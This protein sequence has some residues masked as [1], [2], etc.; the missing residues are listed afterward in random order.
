MT[1]RRRFVLDAAHISFHTGRM[2]D[3]IDD[4]RGVFKGA[5]P[6]SL[7]AHVLIAALLI[8]GLPV[9][10]LQP[11]EEPAIK[12]ELVPPDPQEKAKAE[13]P[14]PPQEKQKPEETKVEKPPLP[15]KAPPPAAL[16][17]VD[18]F[19]EKDAG[20][21]KAEGD[22]ATERSASPE[23]EDEPA[24]PE[25]KQPPAEAAAAA[26]PPTS[27]QG[28]PV[29]PAPQ[30]A[31]AAKAQKAAKTGEAKKLSSREATGDA[32]ATTAMGDVPRGVR[33]GRLCVTELRD[34]LRNSLPPYFPDL[35]PSYRLEEGTVIDVPRAAFRV[36]G[37]WY[38]L[39][40][41][42]QVDTDATKVVSFDFRVGNMLPPSEW[43]RRGLPSQ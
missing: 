12:V 6:A 1:A 9:S 19:G 27:A 17:P 42:C 40:Y 22:S 24:K 4:Q 43:K 36:G 37:A 5:L 31:A 32:I 35:L 8:F 23:A 13:P 28:A 7:A 3:G 25:P 16:A 41:R 38:D 29:A 21:R 33:A 39:S 20:P 30:P 10:L 11:Q 34:Q 2:K 26:T 15:S 14:P 18:Q